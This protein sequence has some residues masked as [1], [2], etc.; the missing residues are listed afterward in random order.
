MVDC[1]FKLDT[2][3]ATLTHAPLRAIADGF[4]ATPI[5]TGVQVANSIK[6]FFHESYGIIARDT[7]SLLRYRFPSDRKSAHEEK[8]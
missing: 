8:G 3:I 2:A 4:A 6:E 1:N 7:A 5:W